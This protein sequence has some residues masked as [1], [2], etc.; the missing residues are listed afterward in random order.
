MYFSRI[1]RL[2]LNY[3]AKKAVTHTDRKK[4]GDDYTA[5]KKGSRN[6]AVNPKDAPTGMSVSEATDPSKLDQL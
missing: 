3:M 2:N 1:I 5:K 4:T 6:D